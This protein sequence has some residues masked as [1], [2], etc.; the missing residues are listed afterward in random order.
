MSEMLSIISI[1][2]EFTLSTSLLSFSKKITH[3]IGVDV[4]QITSI[5]YY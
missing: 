2:I 4:K 1:F 3:M 5:F